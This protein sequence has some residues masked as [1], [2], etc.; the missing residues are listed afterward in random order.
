MSEDRVAALEAQV[1]DLARRL[2]VCEDEADVRKLQ[3]LY[4]YLID[5]CLYRETIDLFTED[6]EVHFF[7]GIFRGHAG[8]R[9][10]YIDRF[11]KRFTFGNNGPIDGFLLEHPQVQDIIHVQADGVTAFGRAR[12]MMQAG[13]HRDFEG[14]A[15]HL[16]SRQW[17][18]GGIYENTYRKVDNIWRIHVLNY[19]PQW[20]ADFATGWA[21]TPPHYVPFLDTCYPEDPAGPDELKD[22]VWLW[23]THRW[24]P[25]HNPHPVTGETIVAER[26]PQ[27]SARDKWLATEA[28][29]KA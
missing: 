8:A 21:Q 2:T 1:V 14:D 22:D 4:G 26:M 23:P 29:R 13:R 25:Y 3:H 17:W 11:Q 7:G 24:V 6:C 15:P 5:K 20:H 19:M 10:L 18:E 9:R 12:S 27:D 16:K 28:A